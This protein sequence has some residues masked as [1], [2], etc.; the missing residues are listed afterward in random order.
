MLIKKTARQPLFVS[1]RYPEYENKPFSNFLW[2]CSLIYG[3]M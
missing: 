2:L 1:R 3:S